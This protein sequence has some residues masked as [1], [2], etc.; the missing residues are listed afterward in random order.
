MP[1][2][3]MLYNVKQA[4]GSFYSGPKSGMPMGQ[5][6]PSSTYNAP[7][8]PAAQTPAPVSYLSS[9]KGSEIVNKNTGALQKIETS[10]TGP[11]IVDAL[12]SSGQDSS[13]QNR[14]KLA[15]QAGIQGYTGTAEQNTALLQALRSPMGNS[16]LGAMVNDVNSAVSGG[17]LS[18]DELSGLKGLQGIQDGLLTS[19]AAARAALEA[20]DYTSMD[21]HVAKAKENEKAFADQ[22]SEYYKS[23]APLRQ[24]SLDLMSPGV[25]EQEVAKQLT[26]I[27]GQIDQFNLQTEEDKFGEYEGQTMGFAGGRASEIDIKSEFK[28]TRML[29]K[30]KNLLSE[31]GLEQ[32]AREM[33]SRS[34]EQQLSFLADD[35]ELQTAVQERIQAQ[36]DKLFERATTLRT[37]AQ[38][39][40]A[41]VLDGLYGVDPNS[42][43]AQ[44]RQQLAK[45][46][47]S[48]GIPLDLLEE[49]LKVQHQK[50]V[51]DESLQLAQEARMSSGGGE[52]LAGGIK[53]YQQALTMGL[54]PEGTSYQEFKSPASAD[55]AKIKAIASTIG[56]EIEKL[57]QAFKANYKGALTGITLG[58]NRELVKLVDQ[59]AD[60]I[61]RMRSGGAVNKEEED[62]FKRQ[63]ASASDIA[64]GNV[65]GAIAALDGY[66]TEANQVSGSLDRS[67]PSSDDSYQSY[68][69]A[70][71]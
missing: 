23:I 20:E 2:E 19:T 12:N 61:G 3:E 46:A 36:D 37:D 34:V 33:G 28:R 24:R 45:L 41:S 64:F 16:T 71:K 67:N 10:Y 49:A 25:R 30:E 54:I 66:L 55:T 57:K 17:A 9:E 62:R 53:E 70:I 13:F 32:S 60:K 48:A 47:K 56:P 5:T 35:Y 7:S 68:L 59:I 27:R 44:T 6:A 18:P 50:Q 58:T 31:L 63:I 26:D 29:L 14:S 39:T 65:D 22:L 11:S 51:F 21:F 52:S 42:I 43:P 38:Q 69:D 15:G 40:L 4:D 8:T 1:Q